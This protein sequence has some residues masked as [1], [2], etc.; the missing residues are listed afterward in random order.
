M[1]SPRITRLSNAINEL[2]YEEMME[3][4]GWFASQAVDCDGVKRK[5]NKDH[6]VAHLF[7]CWADGV[8]DGCL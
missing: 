7:H 4:A 5:L 8:R 6:V 3:F 2:T 1:P